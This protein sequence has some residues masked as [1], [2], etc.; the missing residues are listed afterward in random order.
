LLTVSVE[1]ELKVPSREETGSF[2]PPS[3]K[4]ERVSTFTLLSFQRPGA[5]GLARKKPPTRA[6]GPWRK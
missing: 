2:R 5:A 1:L 3:P 6:G 4:R